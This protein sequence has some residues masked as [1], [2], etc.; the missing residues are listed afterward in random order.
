ML[1]NKLSG[2]MKYFSILAYIVLYIG[3][4]QFLIPKIYSF[5]M[6]DDF[7]LKLNVL[8][9]VSFLICL[10]L[11]WLILKQRV[12]LKATFDSKWLPTIFFTFAALL[13]V[14][15]L[16][17]KYF[18]LGLD[19]GLLAAISEEYLFRGVLLGWNVKMINRNKITYFK[20]WISIFIPS[21]LF[22]LAHLTNIHY[23]GL[24][25]TLVQVIQVSG[26]GFIIGA[27]YF[28]TGSLLISMLFHFI[29]DFYLV[30]HVGNVFNKTAV[31]WP[32]FVVAVT[33]MLLFILVGTFIISKHP[34]KNHLLQKIIDL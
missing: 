2:K 25:A 31:S 9:I 22:G 11:N 29:W 20:M 26:I 10:L 17:A 30:S 13:F 23:Q 12:Y 1:E 14:S 32:M 4:A 15:G 28:K 7:V 3:I 24:S 16:F 27:I 33:F 8:K 34:Q 19:I 5:F 6:K 18:W 21:V